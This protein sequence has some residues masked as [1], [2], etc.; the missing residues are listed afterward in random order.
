MRPTLSQ[1][2]YVWSGAV[3]VSVSELAINDYTFLSQ[4]VGRSN[5]TTK[6]GSKSSLYIEFTFTR[7]LGYYF[8]REIYPGTQKKRKIV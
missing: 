6:L 8:M 2:K 4:A 3:P 5:I 1:V 7:T